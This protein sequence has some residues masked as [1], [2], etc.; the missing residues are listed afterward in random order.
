MASG[1]TSVRFHQFSYARRKLQSTHKKPD[2]SL[3]NIATILIPFLTYCSWLSFKSLFPNAIYIY[4]SF[5]NE[6][7]SSIYVLS[8]VLLLQICSIQ[9]ILKLY[10]SALDSFLGPS[11]ASSSFS[12][13]FRC[14]PNPLREAPRVPSATGKD[15]AHTGACIGRISRQISRTINQLASL[16]AAWDH[17]GDGKPGLSRAPQILGEKTHIAS[18]PQVIHQNTWKRWKLEHMEKKLFI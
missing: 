3:E 13:L 18:N 1:R 4:I 10:R 6:M 14:V 5:Q 12:Q 15:G 17:Q 11:T 7:W 9:N 8:L 16:Q 2:W